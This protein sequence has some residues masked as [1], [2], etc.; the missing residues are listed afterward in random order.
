MDEGK[1]SALR[2]R[3]GLRTLALLL[4]P[5]APFLAA[6]LWER[7]GRDGAVFR[8]A[9]P[10]A[11]AELAREAEIE[12]PVQCNGKLVT[13][14]KVPAG[15]DGETIKAAVAGRRQGR[16]ANRR[17]IGG[18]GDRRPRQARQH[19]GAIDGTRPRHAGAWNAVVCAH[20]RGLLEAAFV[21]CAS[22]CSGAGRSARRH[23]H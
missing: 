22:R 3:R 21:D 14:I 1:I 15:S 2:H 7:D 16:R 5:F 19:C 18:Q 8:T 23:W 11:D 10:M 17:Q 20:P 4:A 6:E 12:I 13:V 9:W